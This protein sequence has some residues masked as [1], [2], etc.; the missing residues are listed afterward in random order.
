MERQPVPGNTKKK[1]VS[2]IITELKNTWLKI[3]KN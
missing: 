1:Y 2:V 3:I